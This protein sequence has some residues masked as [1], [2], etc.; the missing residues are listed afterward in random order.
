MIDSDAPPE[1]GTGEIAS[2]FVEFYRYWMPRLTGYLQSQTSDRR[3][4]EDVAQEAM[5]AAEAK[6]DDLMTYD[7]PGAWLFRV[8]TT[9]LRRWQSNAREQCTSLDDMITRGTDA[10]LVA[11]AGHGRTDGHLDLMDAMRA[12]PRR[13]REAIALHSLLGFPLADVARIMGIA[14]G[15]AKTHVHRARKRLEEALRVPRPA[16]TR[17]VKA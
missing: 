3:W 16:T 11:D 4:I 1:R 10:A 9:M 14:E 8:A 2:S 13:Q 15:S 12:L 6:W 5:L 17:G 7:K